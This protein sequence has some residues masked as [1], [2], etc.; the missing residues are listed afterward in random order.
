MSTQI[1]IRPSI[2]EHAQEGIQDI[3]NG[4]SEND[5]FDLSELHHRLFNEDYFIIGSYKA[6]QWIRENN[7]N[8]WDVIEEVKDY[9]E[10]NFGSM[11]TEINAE[12]MVNMFAYIQGEA[13]LNS[14]E[15]MRFNEA[16]KERME[17]ILSEIDEML[18]K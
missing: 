18:V 5:S 11:T 8:A 15:N 6:E 7:L 2:V 13:L 9:E 12:A 10:L 3:I 1:S 17:A 14:L 16:D 4:M